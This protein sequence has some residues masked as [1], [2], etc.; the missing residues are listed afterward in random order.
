MSPEVY[1]F[2][3]KK[4]TVLF[5]SEFD[6]LQFLIQR[7]ENDKLCFLPMRPFW[8]Q[9]QIW[10]KAERSGTD[11]RKSSE[12]Q[13]KKGCQWQTT[14]PSANNKGKTL[15]WRRSLG[16][17]LRAL[18]RKRREWVLPGWRYTSNDPRKGLGASKACL[19]FPQPHNWSN[20]IHYHCRTCLYYIFR[21]H[22]FSNLTTTMQ[23]RQFSMR[24]GASERWL[25]TVT[26]R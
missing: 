2:P 4:I 13:L 25:E 16:S 3:W 5:L 21:N 12:C 8:M 24:R 6:H 10:S 17:L 20:K 9:M 19:L 15:R 18:V 1:H 23:E 22:R 7:K 11:G 26:S 14:I